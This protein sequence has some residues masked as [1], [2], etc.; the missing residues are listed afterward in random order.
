MSNTHRRHKQRHE[1]ERGRA[2][3]PQ[4]A[5]MVDPAPSRAVAPRS[6]AGPATNGAAQSTA[7]SANSAPSGVA[8]VG[9]AV[10]G[11]AIMP[12]SSGS[13]GKHPIS[14]AEQAPPSP[15][16]PPR[17][18]EPESENYDEEAVAPAISTNTGRHITQRTPTPSSELTPLLE[19]LRALFNQDRTLSAHGDAVRCGICYLTFPR[20]QVHY[21]ETEGFYACPTCEAALG[22]HQLPMIHRQRK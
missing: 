10:N 20:D 22:K 14:P 21:H 1:N 19:A 11:K 7:A 18:Q 17:N 3:V 2:T 15:P 9:P 4:P 12:P 8:R 5:P 13:N 16:E 6:A